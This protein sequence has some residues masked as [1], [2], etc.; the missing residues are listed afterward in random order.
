MIGIRVM[1][2]PLQFECGSHAFYVGDAEHAVLAI[3]SAEDER[4]V[5]RI[6]L[7]VGEGLIP[8]DGKL[9][10][11]IA[12]SVTYGQ[13]LRDRDSACLQME[14]ADN[15]S[16]LLEDPVD[17]RTNLDGA[18]ESIGTAH[19][20]AS[21]AFPGDETTVAEHRTEAALAAGG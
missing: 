18:T 6:S 12:K 14:L 19:T 17:E 21:E 3:L 13:L 7:G 11:E 2:V 8:V 1:D 16:Q 15:R 5:L 4:G 20:D 10:I 9:E